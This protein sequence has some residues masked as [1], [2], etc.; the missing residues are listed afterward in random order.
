MEGACSAG[1][2]GYTFF[3]FA[4]THKGIQVACKTGTAEV[5]TNGIPNA[6][7]T[8]FAP[9]DNP[10]IVVTVLFERGGEG[11]TVAGPV[12]RKIADQYFAAQS[13]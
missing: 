2:T 4:A 7:F 8:F 1:G 12:A 11:S 13:N 10:Q 9:A 5:E 3:D 6:W